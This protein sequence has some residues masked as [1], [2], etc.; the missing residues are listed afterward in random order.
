MERTSVSSTQPPFSN[1][2][3]KDS[4]I[5]CIVESFNVVRRF[6]N[7]SRSPEEEIPPRIEFNILLSTSIVPSLNNSTRL[8][9]VYRLTLAAIFKLRQYLDKRCPRRENHAALYNLCPLKLCYYTEL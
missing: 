7:L 5:R 4:E 3:C 8:D 9:P 6:L 2:N 1:R